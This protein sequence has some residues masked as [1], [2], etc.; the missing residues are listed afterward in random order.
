MIWSASAAYAVQDANRGNG[1]AID[2]WLRIGQARSVGEIKAAVSETL[3]IPWVNTIASDR[4]GDAL[5]ADIAAVPNV[6][7]QLIA[8]CSTPLCPCLRG[9]RHCSTGRVPNATGRSPK[10]RPNPA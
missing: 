6:S 10:A 4:H 9:W 3:G 7:A 5:H 2:T 8:A 1:R